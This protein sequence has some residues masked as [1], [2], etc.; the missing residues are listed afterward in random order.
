[1]RDRDQQ[2]LEEA[3]ED[4]VKYAKKHNP[5]W[6]PEKPLTSGDAFKPWSPKGGWPS[7][8]QNSVT[9]KPAAKNSKEEIEDNEFDVEGDP[10]G[11][12]QYI[13][14]PE[15]E[16]DY[17]NSMM[18]LTNA[19]I[20]KIYHADESLFEYIF[21]SSEAAK[22]NPEGISFRYIAPQIRQKIEQQVQDVLNR[23]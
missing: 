19:D 8:K 3:Y 18:F 9:K 23:G 4:I 6:D 10:V 11:S 7:K 14:S 1:M 16:E 12:L 17:S 2:L 20:E 22:E 21:K 13:P 5:N 15:P